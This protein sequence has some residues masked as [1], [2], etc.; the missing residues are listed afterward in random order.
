M[1]V[2]HFRFLSDTPALG[3][4]VKQTLVS[5]SALPVSSSETL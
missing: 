5:V 3:C 4:G 2:D 1:Y